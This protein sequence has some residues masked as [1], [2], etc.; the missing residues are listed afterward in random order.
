MNICVF[1][2]SA[3][4]LSSDY[5]KAA[6]EVGTAIGSRGHALV[7]GGYEMGLM[8][9][10]ARSAR[11][12][13]ARVIGVLPCRN[14]ELDRGVFGCD[15]IYEADGLSGR[16]EEMMRRSDAFVVLPG[17]FGTLDELYC[18]LSA[19]K[20][21]GLGKPGIADPGEPAEAAD[22]GDPAEAADPGDPADRAEVPARCGIKP[23]ALIDVDGFYAPVVEL[24]RRMVADGFAK[25]EHL[26]LYR[27]FDDVLAAMAYLEGGR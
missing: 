27:S 21:F 3:E 5:V 6:A 12:A 22:P 10:V 19:E 11:D 23:V 2:S 7:F 4:G 16:K 14:G 1:C 17:A 24:G 25:P 15:E 18:V 9:T 26:A 13:G 20:L 8:G